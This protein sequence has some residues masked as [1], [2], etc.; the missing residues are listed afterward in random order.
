MLKKL[1]F[2][3]LLAASL[4]LA[5]PAF[6]EPPVPKAHAGGDYWIY[7]EHCWMDWEVI[8]PEL[9][10]RITPTWPETDD[11]PGALLKIDWLVPQWPVVARFAKGARLRAV[12]D[13]VGGILIKDID[14]GSWMKV[15]TPNGRFCFVRANSKYIRPI[16]VAAKAPATPPPAAAADTPGAAP[17]ASPATAPITPAEHIPAPAIGY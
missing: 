2:S 13:E 14:G 3:A 12:P 15:E 4:P 7:N 16:R 17:T 1:L 5:Q 11:D 8:C 10:G 9:V 6:A